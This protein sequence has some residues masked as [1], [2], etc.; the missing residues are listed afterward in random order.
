MK[1]AAWSKLNLFLAIGNQRADGYHEL[2][3]IF[4]TISLH[5][6]LLLD[7]HTDESLRDSFSECDFQVF[8]DSDFPEAEPLGWDAQNTLYRAVVHLMRVQRSPLGK[9]IRLIKRIPTR[10][11]LGGGSADAGALIRHFGRLW[12]ISEDRQIQIARTIGSDVP[13]FLKGGTAL[14]QGTGERVTAMPS[15]PPFPVLLVRPPIGLATSDMYRRLDQWRAVQ[16]DVFLDANDEGKTALDTHQQL[17]QQ[18]PI[19]CRNDFFPAL[20]GID[21]VLD[22]WN[23]QWE[24]FHHPNLLAKGMTGSGSVFFAVFHTCVPFDHIQGLRADWQKQ[25]CWSTAARF[26]S[27]EDIDLL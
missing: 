25:G 23:P 6:D 18:K 1:I 4:Q 14:V 12:G 15:L 20:C 17:C 27:E 13:F 21:P 8:W 2:T 11:G 24:A 10:S 19:A 9:R 22:R 3:S 26:L 7:S 5:D 16:R